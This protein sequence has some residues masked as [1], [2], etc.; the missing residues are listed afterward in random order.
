V[1]WILT[2]MSSTFLSA[3]GLW[4]RQH[5]ECIGST[6]RNREGNLSRTQVL[7]SNRMCDLCSEIPDAGKE[8]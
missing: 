5:V 8:I 3:D 6:L 1:L 7:P 4:F 2:R